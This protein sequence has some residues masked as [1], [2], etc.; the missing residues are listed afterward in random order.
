MRRAGGRGHHGAAGGR[1]GAQRAEKRRPD[2]SVPDQYPD[3]HQR[4]VPLC[5]AVP[6]PPAGR[7]LYSGECHDYRGGTPP[8][9]GGHQK[10]GGRLHHPGLSQAGLCAG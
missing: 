6:Q 7:P 5:D 2:P 1:P 4:A 3:D 10:R 8:A 9:A